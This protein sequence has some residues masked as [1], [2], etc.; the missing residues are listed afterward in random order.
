MRLQTRCGVAP[1]LFLMALAGH[2]VASRRT[3]RTPPARL[4]T[5]SSVSSSCSHTVRVPA[6]GGALGE[7]I[8][9]VPDLRYPR[10]WFE[11][12]GPPEPP[13]RIES[14][15]GRVYLTRRLQGGQTQVL[16]KVQSLEQGKEGGGG[17]VMLRGTK[18]VRLDRD[19]GWSGERWTTPRRYSVQGALR[20][21]Y[22]GAGTGPQQGVRCETP[23]GR[24]GVDHL[25]IEEEE[26]L[27]HKG[28][29]GVQRTLST[30]DTGL[31]LY[32]RSNA[33]THQGVVWGVGV[34]GHTRERDAEEW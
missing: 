3:R 23:Q 16:V 31:D 10:R 8:F 25:R 14:G 7:T 24:R 29:Y 33:E 20:S 27:P 4:S 6:A 21:E 11:I 28:I 18:G 5:F 17:I 26:T 30:E 13:V 2:P 1:L 9:T 22:T 15:S 19:S 12:R 34:S 32:R